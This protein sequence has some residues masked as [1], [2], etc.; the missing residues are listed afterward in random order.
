MVKILTV[1]NDYYFEV[2]DSLMGR[3][4][5]IVNKVSGVPYELNYASPNYYAFT[6]YAELYGMGPD[7]PY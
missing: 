6:K 4:L 2:A 5:L 7:F 1:G 3:D